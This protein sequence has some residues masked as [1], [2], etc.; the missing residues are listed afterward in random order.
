M[1]KR[2]NLDL[3]FRP[4]IVLKPCANETPNGVYS[5][6]EGMYIP[7]QK[8]VLSL[9]DWL[10]DV[11]LSQPIGTE[12]V[13]SKRPRRVPQRVSYLDITRVDEWAQFAQCNALG[14]AFLAFLENF[15][16]VFV[17]SVQHVVVTPKDVE[18]FEV[19]YPIFNGYFSVPKTTE[20]ELN[21]YL[22]GVVQN[23]SGVFVVLS[24]SDCSGLAQHRF[25]E[26]IAFLKRVYRY[27]V[28]LC[29]PYNESAVRDNLVHSPESLEELKMH[30]QL[31]LERSI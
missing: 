17:T 15:G 2:H 16:Y 14:A 19:V 7:S 20:P 21:S 27:A 25:L 31:F 11:E 10:N 6:R 29:I 9:I 4:F 5:T 18:F 3:G 28:K 1:A 12:S 24:T 23:N 30:H 22:D 26:N 13:D 8:S